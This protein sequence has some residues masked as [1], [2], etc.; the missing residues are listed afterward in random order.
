MF[1]IFPFQFF[2]I[3]TNNFIFVLFGEL[4]SLFNVTDKFIRK[5]VFIPKKLIYNVNQWV[6]ELLDRLFIIEWGIQ[7]VIISDRDLKKISEMWHIIFQ[8]MGIKLFIF[9][10]Y[11]PQTDGIL[12]RTNQTMEIIIPIFHDQLSRNQFRFNNIFFP[13]PIQ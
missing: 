6:N 5:I 1:I 4:S 9:T 11:H 13:N 12:K 8:R 3:I 10:V 7:P 2:Y